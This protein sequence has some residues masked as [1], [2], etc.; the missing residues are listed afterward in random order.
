MREPS[1]RPLIMREMSPFAGGTARM[2]NSSE[3]NIN[4][5]DIGVRTDRSRSAVGSWFGGVGVV[6][7]VCCGVCGSAKSY[8]GQK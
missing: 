1:P 7:V 6:C 4:N 2:S 8:T 3:G 5:V